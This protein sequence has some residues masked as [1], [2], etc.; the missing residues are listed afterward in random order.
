LRKNQQELDHT[1]TLVVELDDHKEEFVSLHEAELNR[2]KELMQAARDCRTHAGCC[3]PAAWD[4][5]QEKNLETVESLK[6]EELRTEQLQVLVAAQEGFIEELKNQILKLTA[7]A[8]KKHRAMKELQSMMRSK[9]QLEKQGL[10]GTRM[11]HVFFAHYG[12]SNLLLLAFT[13]CPY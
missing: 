8:E 13:V 3:T 9:A 12:F 5:V 10:P 7:D 6:T 4:G 1:Q 11:M 2:V